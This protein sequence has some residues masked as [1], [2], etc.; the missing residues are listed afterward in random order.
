MT[1]Q[2]CRHRGHSLG[3]AELI[4]EH[5]KAPATMLRCNQYTGRYRHRD[6]S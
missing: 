5:G 2:E 3:T 6:E 4:D 1:H